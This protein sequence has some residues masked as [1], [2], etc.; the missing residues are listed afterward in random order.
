MRKNQCI[1]LEKKLTCNKGD[2]REGQRQVSTSHS[3]FK[4]IN[5]AARRRVL[6]FSDF[7]HPSQVP[8]FISI[9]EMMPFFKPND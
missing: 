9:L 2:Q 1:G 7:Y 5:M 8:F 6:S 4:K 3:S